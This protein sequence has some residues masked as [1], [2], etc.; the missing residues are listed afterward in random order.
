MKNLSFF[1]AI[2]MLYS[3][4]IFAQ[5]VGISNDNSA[6]DNSALLDVKSTSKGMLVPRMTKTQRDSI[7]VPATGLIIFNTTTGIINVFNGTF[8]ACMDGSPADLWKCGQLITDTIEDKTYS[9]VQIGTQCWFAQNLNVGTL[10]NANV[11]QT[12]NG[13]I[14]KYC[15]DN[16]ETYC[17]IFGGSYQWDELMQYVTAEG[18]QG[19]CPPGWHV[20]TN[21]EW[22]ILTDYLGG[23]DVAGGKLKETGTSHWMSPNEG[24]TNSSGFTALGGGICYSYF[25]SFD[26]ITVAG[27]FWT[28]SQYL[29]SDAGRWYLERQG[30]NIFNDN[31]NKTYGLSVRCLED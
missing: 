30:A 21:A 9:T 4:A 14:E 20:P 12:N 10:V 17:D 25:G 6:P 27:Y 23:E 11:N 8:W 22:T 15:I 29:S 1:I 3:N 26:E 2:L 5:S 24:A 31:D 7:A 13:I 19:I 16:D 28:S 18:A